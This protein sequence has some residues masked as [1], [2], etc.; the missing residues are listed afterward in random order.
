M[1]VTAKKINR[2]LLFK[3]PAAY[4]VG[5]RLNS[6]SDSSSES[7]V[8]FRWINQNPFKSLYFAVQSM[9]A[10]LT[11]GALVMKKIQESGRQISMLLINHTGSFHKK[12]VG[13][14]R[15]I[16]DD[17]DLIDNAVQETIDTSE[18]RVIKM[19]SKGIDESGELV[20]TYQFEWSIKLKKQ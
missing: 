7:S 15:F 4:L 9:G 11:T 6:L 12:A 19:N 5:V 17:G 8:R 14:I 18:G 1:I 13:R 3:L 10:E 20:C 16:C 2:F